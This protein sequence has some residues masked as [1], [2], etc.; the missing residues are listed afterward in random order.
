MKNYKMKTIVLSLVIL[1][2]T[3][4]FNNNNLNASE[5]SSKEKNSKLQ[6]GIVSKNDFTFIDE[7]Y[8]LSGD[9]SCES[10][11]RSMFSTN[12]FL[13]D[14]LM[15]PA[16]YGYSAVMPKYGMERFKSFFHNILFVRR[17]MANC[18]QAKFTGAGVETLRFLSNTT[19]G[20]A[21]FYDPAKHWFG[22]D[23]H[24]ED[25]GQVFTTWGFNHGAYLHLP[26][27]GPTNVR[28]GIGVA[29]DSLFDPRTY[30]FFGIGSGAVALEKLNEG[31]MGYR[32]LDMMLNSFADPYEISKQ[33][34]YVTRYI[35]QH[36]IDNAA[37]ME[38]KYMTSL[39]EAV[40]SHMQ[41]KAKKNAQKIERD[42]L[43]KVP[44]EYE[45]LVDIDLSEFHTQD[46]EV[47]TMRYSNF[48]IQNDK[49]SAWVDVSPWN[50]DF[51]NQSKIRKIQLKK[52]APEYMYK[53]WLQTAN[54]DDGE[55]TS[56]IDTSASIAVIVPGTG[57][58][59]FSIESAA[60]AEL[61]HSQGYH[62]VIMSNSFSYNFME[63]ASSAM[64][65]GYTPL[66]AK[67]VQFAIDG[68]F[69]DL[70]TN[71]KLRP[72]KRAV[73]GLSMG[74]LQ[75]LFLADLEKQNPKL[76]I[77]KFIAVNTPVN[78]L[79]AVDKIDSL[80]KAWDHW[81]R[82]EQ[83][84][85]SV[86]A[87]TKYLKS[88]SIVHEP[89]KFS[90][91]LVN[92]NKKEQIGSKEI[93]NSE[94]LMQELLPYSKVEAQALI[95]LNFKITLAETIYTIEK[96]R[97]V[98]KYFPDFH[99]KHKTPFYQ[100]VYK[101]KFR[102][103]VEKYLLEGINNY[104]NHNLSLARLN[105]KASLQSIP[106]DVLRSEKVR[107]FLTLDDLFVAKKDLRWLNKRAGDRLTVFSNGGHLGL[108]YIK[109]FQDHFIKELK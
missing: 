20:L 25:F 52:N 100:E 95:A 61:I 59:I 37:V 86:I 63:G 6:S 56:D 17:F 105:E 9:D 94:K 19:V 74:A 33:L 30:L 65:P 106:K 104:Y 24:E 90:P 91:R 80:A 47:D 38:Q 107:I 93:D 72:N 36:D 58:S 50:D 87:G 103:Y 73:V 92:K 31:S 4:L 45:V 77:D 28:D 10:F 22:L 21:G 11:N 85:N 5:Q 102:D 71:L 39:K 84:Y 43:T 12:V 53:L 109:L 88:N 70:R 14:N 13:I 29:F 54:D 15:Y 2:T 42:R 62:V 46:P 44:S 75:T 32:D 51:Y 40:N 82:E 35:K 57:A 3:G 69:Y 66:D 108:L 27:Y 49:D 60:M 48:D 55:E 96:E 8:Q 64:S 67:D 41:N 7:L 78:L 1:L 34:Y 97:K 76:F 81:K 23:S 101:F 83:L 79:Y 99:Q 26:V 16:V 68:I 89:L 18:L 98:S